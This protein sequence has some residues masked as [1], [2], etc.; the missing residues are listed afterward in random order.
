MKRARRTVNLTSTAV[1]LVSLL[2]GACTSVQEPT[3]IPLVDLFDGSAVENA[4]APTVA[5]SRIEWQFDGEPIS[6][7]AA[8]DHATGGWRTI[9]GITGLALRDGHRRL[10]AER[11]LPRVRL[12]PAANTRR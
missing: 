10:G 2:A 3:A 6:S 4:Q 8:Q 7:A 9:H 5:P 1:A 12:R 11:Q